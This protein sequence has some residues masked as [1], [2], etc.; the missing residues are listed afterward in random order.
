MCIVSNSLKL[1]LYTSLIS[2]T[3]D[4]KPSK[5][6]N[7]QSHWLTNRRRRLSRSKAKK[8]KKNVSL[9]MIQKEME[10]KNMKL[11]I[12]NK[13]MIEENEKLRKKALLLHQENQALLFHLQ[14]KFS[15][16]SSD[17]H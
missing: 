15:K 16:T 13:K 3:T 8:N 14:N 6:F 7:V 10:I 17:D 11:Y 12:E 2:Y 5:G 9:K 4:T 1:S